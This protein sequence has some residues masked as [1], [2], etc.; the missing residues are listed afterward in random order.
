M[1]WLCGTALIHSLSVTEKRGS[2]KIWTVLLSI[3]TFS[4]SLLGTFLVR[5]GVL[6]SVHAFATD[7][8]RG[9]FIL[10]F[11]IVVIGASLLLFAW[12]APKVGLG[13]NFN[14]IS[15][16]S[17]LLANNVLLVVA[18]ASVLLGTL[19]PLFLDAMGLGKISVGPPYFDAIFF[20]L[21]APA[22]FLMGIGPVL[23]WKNAKT[24]E[25]ATK[26]KWAFAI[27]LVSAIIVPMVMGSWSV[28][29]SIGLLLGFWIVVSGLVNLLEQIRRL[30]MGSERTIFQVI[31]SLPRSYYGMLVAHFGV[32]VFIFGVTLVKGYE[33]ERDVKL[34]VGE[35]VELSGYRFSL[36]S[37][38]D[39]IGPNYSG[40]KGTVFVHGTD[41]KLVSTLYPEKRFYPVQRMPMTEAAIDTGLFRDLYVS[42]GEALEDG[43]WVVRVYL[44]PFVDWIW[45]GAFLMAL[46]GLLAISDKKYRSKRR[47]APNQ[48][49]ISS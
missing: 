1:P 16:E 39:L 40:V 12:R 24:L 33:E 29:V 19:Y 10:G 5:S 34:A 42:L 22:M 15:R 2:F 9:V 26:L 49:A 21:M 43:S 46:G 18:A 37:L 45:G 47:S 3:I 23:R 20:P 11:L 8:E 38:D 28:F 7:P 35:S 13:G 25:V 4:L 36:T 30:R 48:V 32:A 27:S 44:K 14:F 31:N 41:G 17:A 6:T